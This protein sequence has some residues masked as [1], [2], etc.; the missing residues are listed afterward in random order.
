MSKH[1]GWWNFALPQD[2][3]GD[4]DVDILAGNLGQNAR[5]RPT[6]DEPLK[7][8]V[9]DY[10]ENDQVEAVLTYHLGGREIP[11]ANSMEVTKQLPPLKKKYLMSRDFAAA[12]IEEVFGQD[13]IRKALTHEIN[14]LRSMYFENVDGRFVGHPLPDFQQLAPLMTAAVTDKGEV[15]LGGNFYEANIELGRYD[16]DFG[17]VL[18]IGTGGKL[19]CEPLDNQRITGQIRGIQNIEVNGRPALLIARN[20]D[21]AILLQA[22]DKTK[23]DALTQ[24]ID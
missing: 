10:D 13:K 3:D 18:N 22:A 6:D 15:V 16:A 2:F 5:L 8:Y 17:S 7:L 4:G 12:S 19:T 14:E 11:F 21:T 9:T 23:T 1:H 24:K 20:N